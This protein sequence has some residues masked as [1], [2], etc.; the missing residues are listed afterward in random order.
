MAKVNNKSPVSLP[1]QIKT[2]IRD[3]I[4]SGRLK[5]DEKLASEN[6]LAEEYGVSRMTA[7]QALIELITEGALYRIP[8]KG[9]FASDPPTT[10]ENLKGLATNLMMLIVPNLRHS[11][12][13]QIIHGIERTATGNSYEILLRSINEDP[14]E[15]RGCLQ[16][17]LEGGVKGLILIAGKYSHTNL[18]LLQK[19]K[20]RIPIVIVDVAVSGLESDLV[21]S[22]DRGGAF[23]ITSHLVELN[24]K[25]ILHLAGPEGDSSAEERLIGYREALKKYQIEFQPKLVRFTEWHSEEGYYET[26]KF[27]LNDPNQEKVTAIFA[28]NDEVATGAFKA[29]A[30]LKV[31]VPEEIAL[32]GYGNLNIGQL[33]E[34][35]LTTVNQSA[36]EMGEV[37]SQ[38][39]LDKLA[40]VRNFDERKEVRVPTKLVIRQSCGIQKIQNSYT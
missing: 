39:L 20:Q 27:L 17:V 12:F 33:L 24:H 7:R 16:K 31:K 14:L 32:V 1:L 36:A 29:L 4:L 13:Y 18:N 35:P 25:K 5:P 3:K 6:N 21:V 40:G 11:F 23:L 30:E 8:G 26:K 10:K 22:D 19:I 38:L 28:G 15:E 2:N 37:A 9:T 34:I